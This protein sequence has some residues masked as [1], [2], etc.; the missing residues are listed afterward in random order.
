MGDRGANRNRYVAERGPALSVALEMERES[1]VCIKSLR[2]SS[3][4]PFST[5]MSCSRCL[6]TC[7]QHP[8]FS[9]AAFIRIEY[10]ASLRAFLAQ[11]R[12]RKLP[13]L[14]QMIWPS[15]PSH[16]CCCQGNHACS[17]PPLLSA[18]QQH[19]GPQMQRPLTHEG[20]SAPPA[21]RGAMLGWRAVCGFAARHPAKPPAQRC[22]EHPA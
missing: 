5:L 13:L 18:P 7:H 20:R 2:R 1:Q 19:Q 21:L 12:C 6:F 4:S 9:P 3:T 15:L 14:P 22:R 17:T 8:P 10:A 16:R 11:A